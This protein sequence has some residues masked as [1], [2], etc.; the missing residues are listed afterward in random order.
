MPLECLQAS[1]V[2][3]YNLGRRYGFELVTLFRLFMDHEYIVYTGCLRVV[4]LLIRRFY[5]QRGLKRIE[6]FPGRWFGW[7]KRSYLDLE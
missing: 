5:F 6:N 1:E 7:T 3:E 2:L 4:N